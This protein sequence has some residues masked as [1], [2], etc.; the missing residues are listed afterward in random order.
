MIFVH[1]ASGTFVVPPGG[2]GTLEEF[3]DVLTWV[4]F[5]LPPN[6]SP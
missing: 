2:L 3:S 5:G 1:D 6:P 4:Q